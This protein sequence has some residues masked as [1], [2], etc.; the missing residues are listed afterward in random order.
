MRCA[1][2]ASR[3]GWE[4]GR[5]ASP[6]KRCA[7]LPP[8]LSLSAR[9]LTSDVGIPCRLECLRV[10]LVH[11]LSVA[12][13]RDHHR[14]D[15]IHLEMPA[16]SARI[17]RHRSARSR[18]RAFALQ[19]SSPYLRQERFH[20]PPALAHEP[21]LD[22]DVAILCRRRRCRALL[23]APPPSAP[24]HCQPPASSR[25]RARGPTDLRSKVGEPIAPHRRRR[26]AALSLR[27][28]YR[29][30]RRRVRWRP[31]VHSRKARCSADPTAAAASLCARPRRLRPKRACRF[32]K[33]KRPQKP[34][35]EM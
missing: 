17:H 7:C 19:Q 12:H 26:S 35:S 10:Q 33:Q 29:S 13:D 22:V 15:L 14:L 1:L 25:R 11:L 2:R 32:A 31:R 16:F 23:D 5:S 30:P 3:M 21:A 24:L 34:R 9:M 4:R 6:L 28:V 8:L 18:S 27:E 20:L